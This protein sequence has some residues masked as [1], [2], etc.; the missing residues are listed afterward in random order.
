MRLTG[1]I[2]PVRVTALMKDELEPIG[3]FDGV[4]VYPIPGY[5]GIYSISK[6]GKVWIHDRIV[7]RK[8]CGSFL[9]KGRWSHPS[10]AGAGYKSVMLTVGKPVRRY[11]HRLMVQTFLR[12][13]GKFDVDHI[14]RN[15]HNNRID[16]LRI[17]SKSNNQWNRGAQ[18]GTSKFRGVTKT[19]SGKWAA[20]LMHKGR[21]L[22]LGVHETEKMAARAM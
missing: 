17:A 14:D 20:R 6:C 2:F 19:K 18:G 15:K 16:N 1:V 21:H 4:E 10:N 7:V 12:P 8:G 11:V 3:C 9:K 13:E 5:E 22:Y